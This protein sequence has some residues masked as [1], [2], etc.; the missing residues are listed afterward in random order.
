MSR[1]FLFGTVIAAAMAVGVGAQS[2]SP[3]STSPQTPSPTTSSSQSDRQSSMS[4][5]TV[6]VTGCL[7]KGDQSSTTGTTGTTASPSSTTSSTGDFVLNN[8][9]MGG[10]DTAASSTPG[11]TGTASSSSAWRNGL[12]LSASASDDLSKYVNRKVEVSGT[13]DSSGSSMS[14]PPSPST[15]S[16]TTEPSAGASS[17]HSAKPTLKVSS[18]KELGSSCSGE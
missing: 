11:T 1:Q 15:T 10:S 9:S 4:G 12:K 8:V 14:S 17:S 13:I 5:K 3:Q 2:T 18:I 7:Q 6:T 16:P